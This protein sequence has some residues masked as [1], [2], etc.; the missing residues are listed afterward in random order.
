MVEDPVEVL[1]QRRREELREQIRRQYRL[2][3]WRARRMLELH[4]RLIRHL[5]E[6]RVA[7]QERARLVEAGLLP[8]WVVPGSGERSAE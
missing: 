6:N 1:V 2:R 7:R 5:E 4:D 8:E 3:P